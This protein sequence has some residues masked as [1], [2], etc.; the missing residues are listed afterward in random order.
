[1]AT[2]RYLVATSRASMAFYRDAPRVRGRVRHAPGLRDGP[3][4]R[5]RPVARRTGVVRRAADAR[6][7]GARARRLEPVRRRGRGPRPRSSSGCATAGATFR[8]D[9]VKRP[10]RPADPGRR[11]GRQPDRAVRGPR[12]DRGR[13][14][15]VRDDDRRGRARA[16]R[17]ARLLRRRRAAEHRR[18]PRQADGRPGPRARLRGRRVRGPAGA[19][20]AVHRRPDDRHRRHR[21]RLDVRAVRLLP[22]AR[23]DRRRLPGRGPDRPVRQHQHD[24]HRRLRRPRRRGCRGRAGRARSRSTPA[25]C[26]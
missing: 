3:A 11:P 12:R 21:R 20:A 19:A 5:P 8:N 25:T 6:R 13:L 18:Q 7:P 14:L 23:P 1:M 4:R 17:P 2:V 22:A 24:G 9:I 16:G 26:S 15:Q 10:R